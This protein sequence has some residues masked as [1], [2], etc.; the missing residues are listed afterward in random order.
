M[1]RLHYRGP[2]CLDKVPFLRLSPDLRAYPGLPGAKAVAVRPR[3]AQSVIVSGADTI[4]EAELS[5]LAR[6]DADRSIWPFFLYASGDEVV[7][8]KQAPKAR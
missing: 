6:C 3:G 1:E 7:L 5:A 2:F 8:S 4:A